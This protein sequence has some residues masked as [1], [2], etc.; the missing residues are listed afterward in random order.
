[1]EVLIKTL[2]TDDATAGAMDSCLCMTLLVS[3][4]LNP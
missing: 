2:E 4:V 3:G 1:M